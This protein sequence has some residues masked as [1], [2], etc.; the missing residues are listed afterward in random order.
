MYQP[1]LLPPRVRPRKDPLGR[2][3]RILVE[4]GG[5]RPSRPCRWGSPCRRVPGPARR[6]EPIYLRQSPLEGS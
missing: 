3:R 5:R 6:H 2:C 1:M 4:D